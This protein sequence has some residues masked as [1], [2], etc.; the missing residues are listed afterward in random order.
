ML[1]LTL[2]GNVLRAVGGKFK[3]YDPDFIPKYPMNMPG[4]IPL[5]KFHLR[6]LTEEQLKVFT[7]VSSPFLAMWSP[8]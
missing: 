7:E 6:S 2:A 3:V 4:R 8:I 1:H 5:L